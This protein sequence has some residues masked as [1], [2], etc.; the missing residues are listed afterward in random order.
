[1]RLLFDENLSEA[2][3]S[4]MAGEFPGSL[5]VRT[6]GLGGA[7][8]LQVWDAAI[9]HEAVLVTRDEDYRHLRIRRGTP[10]QVV[11]PCL[12]PVSGWP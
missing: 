2:L 7:P 6:L 5:H 10:P 9:R 8:D 11:P 1:M 12:T 4:G 3:V